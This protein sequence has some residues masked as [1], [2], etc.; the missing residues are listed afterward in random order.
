MIGKNFS[1]LETITKENM[2]E[3]DS[4]IKRLLNG[5]YVE[6]FE[7]HFK[8]IKGNLSYVLIHLKAIRDNGNIS[9]IFAI[10]NDI[11]KRRIAE[12]RLNLL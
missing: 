9:Y 6:P 3:Y 10:G 1:Q 2:L 7:S 8:D 5:E 4:K 12:M 11:T